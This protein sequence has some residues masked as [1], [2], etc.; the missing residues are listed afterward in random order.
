MAGWICGSSAGLQAADVGLIKINGAIGPA[1]ASYIARAVDVAGGRGDACLIIQLD[2]PGGSLDSTRAIVQKFYAST[3]PTVVYVAPDGAWAGSA[4]CFITLAADVA[5]MS[6]ATSI[7]AAHPVSIGMGGE[8]KTSDVMKE[9]MENFASSYIASIA[10]KRGRN[11]EWAKSSVVTSQS[12]TATN[13]LE[14]KVID[15]IAKDLPDLLTQLDDREVGGKA[16]KT[17]SANV[18]DIP[19]TTQEKVLQLLSHPELMLILMLVAIYGIIGELSNPGS[20]FPGVVG[21]IALILA[22]YMAAILPINIAGIALIVLALG[23]FI[24]DV[25]APTHGVLTVGGVV[26]FFLGALMLFDRAEPAFRLSLSIIIPATVV[27]AAFFIFVVGAGLRAQFLP[28][29]AGK[30]AMLGKIVPALARIDASGGK[31]FI[32][33]EYWNAVSEVVIEKDQRVEIVE[34]EGLTLKVKPLHR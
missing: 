13:A 16:L 3:V 34:I 29:R 15:L 24:A 32:E 23:L 27:T 19:M 25:Y 7:G 9:K 8:E 22:L 6:P 4:G 14:L 30:E 2:T 20:I 11:I 33:G 17:A 12:I 1:T 18:V 21:A 26:S 31:V 5:A 10:E 28:V